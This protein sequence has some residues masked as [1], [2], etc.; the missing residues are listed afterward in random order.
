VAFKPA[1]AGVL[2]VHVNGASA[3]SVDVTLKGI[4]CPTCNVTD[5]GLTDTFAVFVAGG[6]HPTN[7]TVMAIITTNF[8]IIFALMNAFSRD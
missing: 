2:L 3:A 7:A 1:T 6:G 5:E 8:V 4:A